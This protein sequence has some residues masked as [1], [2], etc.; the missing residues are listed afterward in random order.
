MNPGCALTSLG[1]GFLAC[2]M[3]GGEA[4]IKHFEVLAA[5]TSA[6]ENGAH[7]ASA[8]VTV[9]SLT[10]RI[11]CTICSD[12]HSNLVGLVLLSSL[13]ADEET[14]TVTFLPEDLSMQGAP[15]PCFCDPWMRRLRCW[16][17]VS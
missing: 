4:A 12:P 14:E 3:R 9:G 13:F 17:W 10:A 7:C 15:G 6:D 16:C 1:L 5:L 8:I 11:P 2:K